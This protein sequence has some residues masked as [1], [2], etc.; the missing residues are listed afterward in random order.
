MGRHIED[1]TTRYINGLPDA[2]LPNK[3]AGLPKMVNA[4]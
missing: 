4:S 1:G 3:L 2:G